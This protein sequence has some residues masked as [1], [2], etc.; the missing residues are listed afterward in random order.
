MHA[1]PPVPPE[2]PSVPPPPHGSPSGPE[3]LPPEIGDP[4]PLVTPS[5]VREPPAMPPPMA[6]DG[7]GACDD[8]MHVRPGNDWTRFTYPRREMQMIG[9]IR[10]GMEIGALARLPCGD[11]LKLNGDVVELLNPARVQA[12]LRRAQ[13]AAQSRNLADGHPAAHAHSYAR[14]PAPPPVVIIKKRRHVAD[15]ENRVS[16]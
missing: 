13:C 10:M 15:V 11:Y 4:P 5:P 7:Y 14:P 3:P 2:V 8:R 6:G 9:S 1:P 16:S 12:A